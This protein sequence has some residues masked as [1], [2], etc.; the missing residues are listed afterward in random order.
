MCVN[1]QAR[2]LLLIFEIIQVKK[3]LFIIIIIGAL[4]SCTSVKLAVP[5]Q[6]TGAA[7]QMPVKGLSGWMIN[8]QLTFGNYK[9]S[10]IKKGW[11]TT[12]STSDR[13]SNITTDQRLLN[14]FNVENETNTVSQKSKYHFTLNDGNL[15]TEIYCIEKKSAEEF[16]VKTGILGDFSKTKNSQYSFSAAILPQTV[17][18]GEPW[19]LVLYSL[20]DAAKD[21]T[22]R[23]FDNPYKE[24]EGFATN[25]KETITIRPVYVK[26]AT[27]KDGKEKKLPFKIP[28]G[29]ELRI[30]DGVVGIVDTFGKS[31]W[32]YN[33]LD[34]NTKLILASVS[35][36]LLLRKIES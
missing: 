5:S 14:I 31:V 32:L 12:G 15:S 18:N 20:Y 1:Y 23:I 27:T 2:T 36:A 6:F 28:S 26:A 29:F 3:N 8:Q 7:T 30:D 24:E 35:S 9:T 25:G 19:Q 11:T 17:I 22:K 13:T 33:D 21:T 10:I 4:V 34:A 16:V